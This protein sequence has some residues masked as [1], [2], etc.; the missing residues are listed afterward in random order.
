MPLLLASSAPPQPGSS[1]T[2]A[3]TSPCTAPL[4]AAS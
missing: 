4:S 3:T 1:V 2:R